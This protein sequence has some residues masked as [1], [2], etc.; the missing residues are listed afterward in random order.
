MDEY[1][2]RTQPIVTRTK[3]SHDGQPLIV[4]Y[5]RIST[6]QLRYGDY[7]DILYFSTH[8]ENFSTQVE[9]PNTIIL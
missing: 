1:Y 7:F 8:V 9:L 5:L 3:F 2:S 4:T 6:W